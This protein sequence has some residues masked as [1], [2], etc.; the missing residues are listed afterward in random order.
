MDMFIGGCGS[1][2]RRAKAEGLRPC[3]RRPRD[4]VRWACARRPVARKPSASRNNTLACEAFLTKSFLR[5]LRGAARPEAPGLRSLRGAARPAR[6][7]GAAAVSRLRNPAR[8]RPRDLR[9][10]DVRVIADERVCVQVVD[11]TAREVVRAVRR[12][13]HALNC[14]G[15]FHRTI[16]TDAAV[17]V[18][19]IAE[20]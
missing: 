19:L 2:E 3:A 6:P 17:N 10:A 13:Q 15:R 8:E 1:A 4:F 5:S 20:G 18:V 7:S 16:A 11:A 12:Q 14:L 9:S